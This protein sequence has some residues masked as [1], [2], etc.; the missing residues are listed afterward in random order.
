MALCQR[1]DSK[2]IWGRTPETLPDFASDL[3]EVK[4][5]PS[6]SREKGLFVGQPFGASIF[7][8]V[9]KKERVG[10]KEGGREGERE[11]AKYPPSP[12]LRERQSR[13]ELVFTGKALA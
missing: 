9:R 2:E 10:G 7:T 13:D 3:I 12:R 5:W 4:V 8:A 1:V 6:Q 11:R